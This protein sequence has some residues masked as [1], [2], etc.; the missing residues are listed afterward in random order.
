MK[1]TNNFLKKL[2][3]FFIRT[4]QIVVSPVLGARCRFFPSCSE[5][6]R[7]A[8]ETH[9][10]FEGGLKTLGRV[11]RCHPFHPGGYDPV[12]K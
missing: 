11:M 8:F 10:V 12:R 2:A 5:Y 6:A 9:G 7:Q 4:Y 1:A 3:R